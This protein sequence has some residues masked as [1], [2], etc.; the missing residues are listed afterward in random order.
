[1]FLGVTF[2]LQVKYIASSESS[3]S[4]KQSTTNSSPIF[5]LEIF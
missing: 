1:M 5:I 2:N 3:S 4:I